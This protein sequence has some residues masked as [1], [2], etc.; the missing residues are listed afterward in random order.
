MR[1]ISCSLTV[2]DIH[3]HA[4]NIEKL[5]ELLDSLR[6][7]KLKSTLFVIPFRRGKNIDVNKEYV[8]LLK[9]YLDEGNEIGLHG[10]QHY[11]YEFG[12]CSIFSFPFPSFQSQIRKL[13]K[14]K[15]Y[16]E[17]LFN[18]KIY[19]F[20]APRYEFNNGTIKALH[21]LKFRYDSSMSIFKPTHLPKCGLRFRTFV[22]PYP[23]VVNGGLIE[24]PVTG[25]HYNQSLNFESLNNDIEYVYNRKGCF[26]DNNHI[27]KIPIKEKFLEKL[28]NNNKLKFYTLNYIVEKWQYN[29]K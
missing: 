22:P 24:I 19:G 23:H 25:D 20:R 13:E 26:I 11:K 29:E 15:R 9:N 14:G 3:P 6:R 2:D 4:V 21:R 5:T 10:F 1:K 12:Y 28:V 8:D 18:T 27:Q 16:L 7:Y 17:D